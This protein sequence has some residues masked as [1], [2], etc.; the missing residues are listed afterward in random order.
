MNN[1]SGDNDA[2][3]RHHTWVTSKMLAEAYSEGEAG[4][5]GFDFDP[6]S[7]DLPSRGDLSTAFMDVFYREDDDR[8]IVVCADKDSGQKWAVEIKTNA[9]SS[10]SPA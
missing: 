10:L 3:G 6:E 8:F 4:G 7:C 9:D 2:K 1:K 5:S